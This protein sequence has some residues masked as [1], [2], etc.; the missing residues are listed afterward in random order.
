MGLVDKLLQLK[1][2]RSLRR[3]RAKKPKV[4]IVPYL[5]KE[6][7]K[8]RRTFSYVEVEML[9]NSL[10]SLFTDTED[11]EE[12]P[13]FNEEFW[14]RFYALY[15]AS[16]AD[17]PRAMGRVHP[18]SLRHDCPRRLYYELSGEVPTDPENKTISPQLQRIFDTG[19]WWHTFIQSLLRRAGVLVGA[20][21]EVKDPDRFIDGKTDGL[22]KIPHFDERVLL[23]VKTMNGFQ[24]SKLLQPV[25]DHLFQASLYGNVL[26]VKYI[27]FLYINKDT[28]EYKEYFVPV[29]PTM[30]KEA[31]SIIYPV[32]ESVEE[33]IAPKRICKTVDDDKAF[34]C[35]YCTL[36]FKK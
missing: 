4:S 15:D 23:E 32:K 21:V 29:S 12:T 17:A 27:L 16:F 24:F 19:T 28:C 7:L 10:H 35:E 22:I 5:D 13:E 1:V 18:S 6:I 20:E 36:C 8:S 26:K 3:R 30:V 2:E 34:N 31:D 11:R 14:R 9:V 33:G 25:E